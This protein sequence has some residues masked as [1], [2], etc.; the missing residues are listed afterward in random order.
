MSALNITILRKGVLPMGIEAEEKKQTVED[1]NVNS[2]DGNATKVRTAPK[3]VRKFVSLYKSFREA[4]LSKLD[5][6][7]NAFY[8]CQSNRLCSRKIDVNKENG[9]F[10]SHP[11]GWF[12]EREERVRRSYNTFA[13]RSL[14]A[15]AKLLS[16]FSSSVESKKIRHG[17]FTENSAAAST[18]ASGST[19]CWMKAV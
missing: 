3:N 4:D 8:I 5:S 9:S 14:E 18:A 11:Y 16:P 10:F 2:F 13:L 12:K 6:L 19:L 15:L 1:V 17:F 7:F